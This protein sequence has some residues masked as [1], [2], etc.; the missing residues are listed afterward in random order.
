MRISMH[1]ET[2]CQWLQWAW[3]IYQMGGGQQD[4]T[5]IMRMHVVVRH[6]KACLSLLPSGEAQ[7]GPDAACEHMVL[8]TVRSGLPES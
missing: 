7:G 6:S 1:S 5:K 4:W 8:Q 2:N 3:L